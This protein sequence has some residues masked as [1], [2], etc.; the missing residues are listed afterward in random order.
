MIEGKT[1]CDFKSHTYLRIF[2]VHLFLR[3]ILFAASNVNNVYLVTIL[4]RR[5]ST[6]YF[7]KKSRRSDDVKQN[8]LEIKGTYLKYLKV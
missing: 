1:K 2:Y 5:V 3:S 4:K 8:G 7:V 6:F